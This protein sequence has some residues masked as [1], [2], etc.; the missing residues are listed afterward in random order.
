MGA[1]DDQLVTRGYLRQELDTF[2]TK[3]ETSFDQKLD[4]RF[5]QFEKKILPWFA[6]E[7]SRFA[8]IIIEQIGAKIG[9]VDEKY[10][11]LPPR[12]I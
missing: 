1:D 5:E 10:A 7:L 6:S 4:I 12:V 8:D 3:L 11:D 9:V 2:E